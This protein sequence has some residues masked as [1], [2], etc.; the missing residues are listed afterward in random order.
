[1]RIALLTNFV[2]PYRVAFYEALTRV[3]GELRVFA[4]T[5]MEGNRD[6]TPDWGSLDVVVQ[7]TLTLHKTWREDGF[8]EGQE[9]HVPYDTFKQL[10]A[11]KPDLII[12]GE[13]S[14]RSLQAMAYAKLTITPIVIWATLSD[15]LE[16]N[17]GAL[18]KAAR[19]WLLLNAQRVIVNGE[20][21]ARYVK[22]FGVADDKIIRMPY[23]TNMSALLSLSIERA[24][25]SQRELLYV[26]AI[27]PR[28][29]VQLLIAALNSWAAAHPDIAL[30]LTLVGNGPLRAQL[31]QQS[32][33]PNLQLRWIDHVE[34]DKLPT[35]YENQDMFVFPTL[36]DEW[37]LVVNEAL[38]AGLPVLGSAYSQAVEELI[39]DGSNGW[40]FAPT[41]AR[42]IESALDRALGVTPTELSRM[43][44]AARK[45]VEALTP[46]N[47]AEKLMAELGNG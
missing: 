12:S 23:T 9:M 45:S 34:Y 20:S 46:E 30:R 8:S 40:V 25:R 32:S 44:S 10:R 38:A 31:Q 17:R 21:G 7:K 15:R 33:E 37:G 3:A 6:W 18:K 5:R 41:S 13:L 22:R 16:Q 4:S 28:K 14:A 42:D 11:Y 43:R 35:I 2:P 24:E 29:G 47:A 1:M 39:V 27:S 19:G 26:G 36:G